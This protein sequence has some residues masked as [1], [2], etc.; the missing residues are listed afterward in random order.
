M[1][2]KGAT[3]S[4]LGSRPALVPWP[5]G[6]AQREHLAAVG[7]ARLLVLEPATPVPALADGEDWIYRGADERDVAARLEGLER[8]GRPPMASSLPMVPPGLT[9]DQHRVA[10]RLLSIPGALVSALDL[11]VADL[12]AVIAS[13]RP[14]LRGAG[15]QIHRVGDA[16][17][18]VE[19]LDGGR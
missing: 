5:S 10:A 1:I 11:A 17:F 15:W 9:D 3:S 19:S 6:A 12:D 16:G 7:R 18:L 8:R 14:R 2:V 4:D 13:L